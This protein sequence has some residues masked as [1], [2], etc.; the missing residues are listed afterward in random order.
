[1]IQV[2][3]IETQRPAFRP[4]KFP[5]QP[6]M[7]LEL[8]ENKDKIKPELVNKNYV[9]PVLPQVQNKS[10]S[11]PDLNFID[12]EEA[13][14]QD[15]KERY[16]SPSASSDESS[17]MEVSRKSSS[18]KFRDDDSEDDYRKDSEP[19]DSSDSD[20]D[21]LYKRRN[22][23]LKMS[24]ESSSSGSSIDFRKK[25]SKSSSSS[26]ESDS[27]SDS[28]SDDGLTSRIKQ[29]LKKDDSSRDRVRENYQ[30]PAPSES[31][32]SRNDVRA[33]PS[34][35]ELEKQG[36]YQQKKVLRDI[37]QPSQNE[38][39]EEDLKRELLY[40]FELLKKSYNN[41]TIPEFSIHSEYQMMLKAYE[42][43]LKKVSLDSS[44]DSY[45]T[46]L[47]GGFMLVEFVLSSWFKLDMQGFSQQQIMSMDKYER[48]LIELGEKSYV[49][50]AKQ[51]PVE[52]RLIFMIIINAGFFIVTKMLMKKTGANLL[53]MFNSMNTGA[54]A[55]SNNIGGAKR[56]M[57]GPDLNLGDIPEL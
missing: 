50:N 21:S 22:K 40:K 30:R 57:K 43:T 46:Y 13:E 7:Y 39:E 35:N 55:N 6:I 3:K 32:N 29:L 26:D 23:G 45:K 14:M 47:I 20:N 4:K 34:L 27:D 15:I 1:M 2:I 38:V 16:E 37:S 51:W 41:V 54:T 52:V 56:K 25:M 36:L 5:S 44:V 8:I 42:S 33:A 10:D 24:K 12:E 17:E 49:P 53:N 48:L 28:D 11:R 31:S 19:S 9:P 18:K